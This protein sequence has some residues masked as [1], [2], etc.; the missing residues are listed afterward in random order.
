MVLLNVF[1]NYYYFIL[2][3]V[4]YAKLLYN[5]NLGKEHKNKRKN[6]EAVVFLCH[7]LCFCTSLEIMK[8]IQF[9][10]ALH[11]LYLVHSN[12]PLITKS[13]IVTIF[14]KLLFET[15]LFLSRYLWHHRQK[16]I[17][18]FCK[19]TDWKR[20]NT[21]AVFNEQH[22]LTIFHLFLCTSCVSLLI[23]V[24]STNLC[25]KFRISIVLVS[26]SDKWL[27]FLWK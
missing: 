5:C 19:K 6:I 10:D 22:Y 23:V 2:V 21:T 12:N 18:Q 16:N 25:T 11:T 4:S 13:T 7:R 9:I 27:W 24:K 26:L 14:I 17:S 8:C 15:N 20:R 1:K 3:F